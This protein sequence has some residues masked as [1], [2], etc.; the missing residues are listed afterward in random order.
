MRRSTITSDDHPA[1]LAVSSSTPL[2]GGSSA[3]ANAR[4]DQSF[5][6]LMGSPQGAA[7]GVSA[8]GQPP[9]AA[10]PSTYMSGKRYQDLLRQVSTQLSVYKAQP[11]H[12][13]VDPNQVNMRLKVGG[14]F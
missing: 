9:A 11:K 12:T 6:V 10:A 3:L 7:L 5:S 13:R 4:P 14:R 1:A 8:V 2:K